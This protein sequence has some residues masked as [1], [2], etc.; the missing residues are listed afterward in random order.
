VAIAAAPAKQQQRS[1]S[2]FNLAVSF[3]PT[4]LHFKMLFMNNKPDN[5]LPQCPML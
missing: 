5:L 2:I 3:C 1:E 4:H